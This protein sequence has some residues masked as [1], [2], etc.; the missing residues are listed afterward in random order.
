MDEAPPREKDQTQV[1]SHLVRLLVDTNIVIAYLHGD[2]RLVPLFTRA[3]IGNI[4]L[5]VSVITEYELLRYPAITPEEEIIVLRLLN[6]LRVCSVERRTAQLA[7]MLL[8]QY[9]GTH[10][11]LLIAATA[12]EHGVPLLTQNA[13]DFRKIKELNLLTEPPPQME[14]VP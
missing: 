3:A 11:D 7:S 10:A 13:R 12:I 9:D 5:T 4:D 14:K 6:A 2:E 8:R 1:A